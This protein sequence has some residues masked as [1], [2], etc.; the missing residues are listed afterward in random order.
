MVTHRLG[1][2]RRPVSGAEAMRAIDVLVASPSARVLLPGRR[3]LPM[4]RDLVLGGHARGDLVFDAQIAAVCL[5]HG[6]TTILTEDRDFH[7]FAGITVRG[8]G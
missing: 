3:F 6:A 5:E 1:P 7:R 4:L 2:L 8:I